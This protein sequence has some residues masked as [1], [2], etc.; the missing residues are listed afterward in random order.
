M[1]EDG[2]AAPEFE[3]L[4]T[5]LDPLLRA[6][7][8]LEFI[9][10]NCHPPLLGPLLAG[11][12]P[13]EAELDKAR[14]MLAHLPE[15]LSGVANALE[16]A[17]GLTLLALAELR[18]AGEGGGIRDVYRALRHAPPALEAIYP[19]AGILPPV[20]RFFLDP[21]SR[22]DGAL[23]ERFIGRLVDNTGVMEFG[24]EQGDRSGFM[25]YV[26]ETYS[27]DEPLPLVMALHGGGG[28][29]RRFLWSWLREA[30]THGAIVAA[31]SSLGDTWAIG[32][33]D[34]DSPN[35][36]G[37]VEFVRSQWSVDASRMLLTGM[38]DGGTFAML[39]GLEAGSPFTHLAP[40]ACG[41]HP[42]FLEVSDPERVRGLPIHYAHGELDW[43]FAVDQARQAQAALAQAGAAVTYVELDDLSH[44]YPRELNTPILEWMTRTAG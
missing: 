7:S 27:A 29:G 30:R 9:A 35:L 34:V 24:G 10:R 17:S 38:S 13:R 4:A 44:C 1:T 5:L 15:Y 22:N 36:A 3:T 21:D 31:P 40:A 41:F 37:I 33:E 20:N 18:S 16:D 25:L 42:M 14:P 19:L 2:E 43:M 28:D 39:S 6:L 23:Q 12:A 11:A 26:P 32:R 8:G